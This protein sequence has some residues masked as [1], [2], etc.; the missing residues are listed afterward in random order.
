MHAERVRGMLETLGAEAALRNTETI[1]SAWADGCELTIAPGYFSR[2]EGRANI[3]TALAQGD[4]DAVLCAYNIDNMLPLLQSRE[5]ELG[6]SIRAGAIDCF[7]ARNLEILREP[8]AFG[9]P[10]I[11]YLAGKY[12]SMAGPAFAV[13]CN[14]L[15]GSAELLRPSGRAFRLYQGFWTAEGAEEY[16]E[17]YGFTT[18]IYENACSCDD[19]MRVIRRFHADADFEALRALAESWTVEDVTARIHAR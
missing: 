19:L 5:A 11:D 8:D 16:A 13:M 10:Q 17:L 9:N 14:A 12:A 7:S 18:G 6:R 2:E 4:Y 15:D 1:L 3:E